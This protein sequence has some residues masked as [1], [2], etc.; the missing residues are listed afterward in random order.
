MGILQR[1]FKPKA[2]ERAIDPSWAALSAMSPTGVTV[3]GTLAENLSTVLACVNAI[4]G[5]IAGLPFWVFRVGNQGRDADLN[6][7]LARMVRDGVNDHQSWP[8]FIS[9]LVA[10]ALLAGN[11]LAWVVRDGAGMVTEMRFIPWANTSAIVLPSGRLV[12]DVTDADGLWGRPGQLHR[13]LPGDYLLLKDRSDSGHLGKSRLSRA[14]ATLRAAW[15]LQE[16]VEATH[17]NMATPSLA[18]ELDGKLSPEAREQLKSQI[19]TFYQ[20]TGN[21][22]RV[23]LADQG[24]KAK[25]LS[26]SPEDM[27]LLQSRRFT[28]EELARIYA[29]PPPLAGDLTHGTF[30][31]TVEVAKW[32]CQFTLTP[33]VRRLEAE[34]MRACFSTDARRTYEVELD[35]SGL[36]RGDHEARW[37]SYEVAVKNR[38]L[39]PNEIRLAEGWNPREGGDTYPEEASGGKTL[40]EA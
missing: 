31:N 8:D 24:L 10:S 15:A 38:I 28:V 22:G 5:T 11:G 12:F 13:L 27:E 40:S 6:H 4:A 32:F 39:T 29:V 37:R 26:I 34:F 19:Q 1:L 7:P 25:P 3:N 21:A 9:S 35:L 18:L 36:M 23:L 30:T 14:A 33:W 20:G 16:H 17:V 2:E